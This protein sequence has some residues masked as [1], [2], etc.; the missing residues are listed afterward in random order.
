MDASTSQSDSEFPISTRL[1]GLEVN[2]APEWRPL[3][4]TPSLLDDFRVS[5]E[6]ARIAAREGARQR[7]A[8]CFVSLCPPI[9]QSDVESHD[10]LF[11]GFPIALRAET[12]ARSR[13]GILVNLK[14]LLVKH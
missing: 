5:H 7:E 2:R 8:H 1:H 9:A 14:G 10:F 3:Q 13:R 12:R 11:P 4:P 6:Q